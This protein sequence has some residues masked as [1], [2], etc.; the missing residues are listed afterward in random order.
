MSIALLEDAL[1]K[2]GI[3]L[4]A[5]FSYLSQIDSFL[6]GKRTVLDRLQVTLDTSFGVAILNF[7]L[8][9]LFGQFSRSQRNEV[10]GSLHIL[11]VV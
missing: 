1:S 6:V 3:H 2:Q 4:S 8:E 7:G 9:L 10:N 11:S 5:E